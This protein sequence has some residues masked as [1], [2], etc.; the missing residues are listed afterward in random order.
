VPSGT[1][2]HVRVLVHTSDSLGP[3]VRK[4]AEFIGP[5][6]L[7]ASARTTKNASASLHAYR[8]PSQH[9]VTHTVTVAVGKL[10]GEGV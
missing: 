8:S 2:L 10:K 5:A 6:P 4:S 9:P 3:P 7:L 1:A